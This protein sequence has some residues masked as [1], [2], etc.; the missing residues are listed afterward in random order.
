M[1]ILKKRNG[2]KCLTLVLTD[3]S[4]STLKKYGKLW[5]MIR[6][7]IRSKSNN[8]DDYNKKYVKIK[9]NSADVL[10]LKKTR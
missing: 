2:N 10:P 6:V 1:G 5:S 8:S 7:L 4:K 3:K 9:F